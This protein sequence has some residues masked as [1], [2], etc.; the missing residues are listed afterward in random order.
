MTVQ[1]VGFRYQTC[2]TLVQP[3]RGAGQRESR[4]R[5]C[6]D[7]VLPVGWKILECMTIQPTTD[8]D[9]TACMLLVFCKLQYNGADATGVAGKRRRYVHNVQLQRMVDGKG[10]EPSTS[11]L[12]TPRSPN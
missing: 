1:D 4:R 12:R 5:F 3:S 7:P 8:T 10:L 9:I 11:A 6:D 2:H